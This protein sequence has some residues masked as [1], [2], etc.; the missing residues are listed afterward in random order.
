MKKIESFNGQECDTIRREME[1]A[2]GRIESKFG[3]KFGINKMRYNND[4]VKVSIDI[5]T[6]KDENIKDNGKIAPIEE[7]NFF[8]K[9]ESYG[10]KRSDFG[11]YFVSQGSTYKIMGLLPNRRK[12]PIL[13]ENVNKGKQVL[14]TA[15]GVKT[16]LD[17]QNNG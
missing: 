16:A 10:L 5:H 2:L 13:V 1:M 12:Y 8:N 14:M 7:I 6:I 17:T 15:S 11:K 4:E 3:I 9:C